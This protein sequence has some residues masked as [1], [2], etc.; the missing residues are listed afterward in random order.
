MTN[1]RR[2]L[3]L[4]LALAALA[5]HITAQEQEEEIDNIPAIMSG[6]RANVVQGNVVY[7]RENA[8]FDLEADFELNQA[9]ILRSASNGRAELLLQPGNFL[10]IGADSECQLLDHRYDRLK[11]LLK[12]GTVSLELL[13]NDWEDTSDF[14]DSLKQGFELIRIITPNSEVFITQ[15]GI[16]RINTA[17]G[18]TELIVRKGE[19]VIDGRRVKEKRAAVAAKGGVNITEFDVKN[20]DAFDT[21][22]RERSDDLI[23]ANHSLKKDAPWAKKKEGREG[24]VNVPASEQQGG[25]NPRVVYA[26]PGTVVFLE[27]GI[28]FNSGDKGWQELTDKFQLSAGDK[29]RTPRYSF[30]ELMMFPD[31]Y[32]R[33]DGESEVLLEQLSN[34]TIAFKVLRGSAILDVARFDRKELPKIAISGPSTTA[35]VV[36]DGNYRINARP[37]TDDIIVRKGK[38]MIQERSIGSCRII[39]GTNTAECDRK[40]TDNFDVWSQH[41]GEGQHFDGVAMATRLAELRRGRFRNS[42]FWYQNPSTRQY[43]FVP[44]FSTYFRSPYGGSYSSVLSPRRSFMLWNGGARRPAPRGPRALIA[45]VRPVP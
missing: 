12:K 18:R 39:S 9:D 30:A 26:R 33:L 17:E 2:T 10:R 1:Y 13:K 34:E 40:T 11:F 7:V 44:F 8:K 16:F 20:E 35:V 3:L 19:A 14:F 5:M 23:E 36:E 6:L 43:T 37:I 31:L 29:V 41:R 25:S 32:L 15:P 22:G 45:P 24:M 28:E 42:G 27:S 21:W 38:V 4:L